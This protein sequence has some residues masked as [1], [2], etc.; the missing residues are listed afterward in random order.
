MESALIGL[1]GVLIG[2]LLGEYFRRNNRI[3]AYSQKVFE[4]RLEIY[5]GLMDL[6]QE[7]YSAGN[8]ALEEGL[9][10]EDRTALVFSAGLKIAEYTDKHALYL[11]SYVAA[12]AASFML[13]VDDIAGM[14]DE[15]E[16]E[17]E[18]SVFRRRY[19][20][21][22]QLIVEE[23]GVQQVNKHFRLISRAKP[24]SP[25]IRR[26]KELERQQ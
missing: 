23:S 3:E 24:D 19:K 6:V 21:L 13:G 11:D 10:A 4:R 12:D 26:L 7:A 18:V 2:A 9:S 15:V 22:K 25:I 17:A 14:E 1:A 8:V 20:A 16:R 5:E